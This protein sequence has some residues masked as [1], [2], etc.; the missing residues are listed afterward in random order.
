[1]KKKIKKKAKRKVVKKKAK[2]TVKRKSVKKAKTPEIVFPPKYNLHCAKMKILKAV[3]IMPCSAFAKD[4]QGLRYAHTQ[5]EKVYQVYREQCE[6]N[7]LVI[8]RIEGKATDA[9]R[10][11][12]VKKG[13]EETGE[14]WW[15]QE[16]VPCVR[17]E[18]IWE[19]EHVPSGEKETFHGAGDGDN[20]IWSCNSAQTV[21]KKQALLDY[22]ET[23][24]PQ[25]TDWP[26]LVRQSLEDAGPEEF[27]KAMKQIVPK[28]I[29]DAT[30][31]L[32][33]MGAYFDKVYQK[34]KGAKK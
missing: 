29:A 32:D 8:R 31:I 3:P 10:P 15:V 23:A 34:S 9:H 25:P 4:K 16:E 20:D 18:G 26:K 2:K 28:K 14:T 13:D 12:W 22:F 17:F 30:G 33:V 6:K 19:I 11:D 21:A 27:I 24:W 1:M 5:A 7:D